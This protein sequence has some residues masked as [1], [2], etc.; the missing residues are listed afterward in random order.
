[1]I[2]RVIRNDHSS[3]FEEVTAVAR[4]APTP[5][6]PQRGREKY[7]EPLCWKVVHRAVSSLPL[8]A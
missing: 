6:L 7:E 1:M 3:F 8:W 2:D 4:D 5:A